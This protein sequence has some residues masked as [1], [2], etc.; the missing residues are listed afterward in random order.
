MRSFSDRE[1]PLL[2]ADRGRV[3]LLGACH[4]A[5]GMS[6]IFHASSRRAVEAL[7]DGLRRGLVR[8]QGV[9]VSLIKHGSIRTECSAR[10]EDGAGVLLGPLRHALTS[11][12]PRSRYY[13]GRV[14]GV[15]CRLV[16]AFS[17]HLPDWAG[18][19]VAEQTGPGV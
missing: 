5:V 9:G 14:R 1:L 15:P 16:C 2:C 10:G 3:V 18:D 17:D 7:A 4:G 11:P 19:Y 8:K 6:H 13:A 12:R